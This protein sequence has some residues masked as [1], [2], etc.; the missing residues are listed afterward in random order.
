[1]VLSAGRLLG[2]AALIAA[3]GADV[4]EAE[5][6]LR[7]R[8]ALLATGDELAEPGQARSSPLAVPDSASLGVSVLAERWGAQVDARTRLSDDLDRLRAAAADAL[9]SSVDI[10]VVIGG[11]S[12]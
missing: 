9:A 6:F 10:V 12:V 4:G 8:L 5:V 2:P 3:A 11:A 1:E 7:P